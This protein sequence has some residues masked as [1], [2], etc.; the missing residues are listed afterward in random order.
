MTNT[1]N[2]KLMAAAMLLAVTISPN[3][4]VAQTAELEIRPTEDVQIDAPSRSFA[5]ILET[6]SAEIGTILLEAQ[7]VQDELVSCR[8][9]ILGRSRQQ[10]REVGL[11]ACFVA[12]ESNMGMIYDNTMAVLGGM[13]IQAGQKAAELRD[14]SRSF[15]ADLNEARQQLRTATDSDSVLKL[16]LRDFA[17]ELEYGIDNLTLDEQR[18]L[19]KLRVDFQR[20]TR[21]IEETNLD[22]SG[23]QRRQSN[24]LVGADTMEQYAFAFEQ[25]KD[26]FMLLADDSRY[27]VRRATLQADPLGLGGDA[28]AIEA[29]AQGLEGVL[30]TLGTIGTRTDRPSLSA[31]GEATEAPS[32]PSGFGN[33]TGSNV[34]WLRGILMEADNG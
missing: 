20:N 11:L 19:H 8:A 29:M 34:D 10:S 22:L 12:F 2:P 17:Q 7:S 27:Y 15:N 25:G 21:L 16:T 1:M 30:T 32:A 13:E 31:G 5:G 14:L 9:E 33:G 18:Q 3:I 26:S 23:T 28:G 6:G 24:L 4:T